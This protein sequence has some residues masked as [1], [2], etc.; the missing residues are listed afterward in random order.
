[1][2]HPPCHIYSKHFNPNW[3]TPL[4]PIVL[5]EIKRKHLLS[6]ER[7]RGLRL[8]TVQTTEMLHFH[9]TEGPFLPQCLF[10]SPYAQEILQQS[11]VWQPISH[12]VYILFLFVQNYIY[13]LC[14]HTC[15]HVCVCVVTTTCHSV[16]MEV[17]KQ[18]GGTSSFTVWVPDIE[19]RSSGMTA[20][21][22]LEHH[23]V[24]DICDK[25]A[26]ILTT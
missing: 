8:W 13:L 6:R 25:V 17:R 10:L 5:K 19:F 26:C 12:I 24:C 9:T 11:T 21:Y 4:P 1:M 23:M 2:E 18:L 16:R 15:V 20:I 7:R 3:V 14:V 22:I